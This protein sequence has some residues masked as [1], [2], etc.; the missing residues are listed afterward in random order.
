M[1]RFL[2]IFFVLL[3]ASLA[4]NSS[5]TPAPLP[6]IDSN[7]SVLQTISVVNTA[8]IQATTIQEPTV[9][10]P[11][12]TEIPPTITE[13]PLVP[14]LPTPEPTS[15]FGILT[16]SKMIIIKILYNG[17]GE[18]E[19]DEYVEIRNDDTQPIQLQHWTFRD[20]A[21]HVFYF[22]EYVMQPGQ[23]CRVYTDE[24][25]PDTCGFSFGFNGSAIWNNDSD[26]AYLRDANKN[27][28]AEYCY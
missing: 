13:A 1:K 5:T 12:D 14:E 7:K 20:K 17:S 8:T 11:A 3:L 16:T 24:I 15:T 18:K 28:I 4:C 26:C 19:P 6:T 23:V 10:P 9:M 2:I 27:P 22:P 21:D 25:H